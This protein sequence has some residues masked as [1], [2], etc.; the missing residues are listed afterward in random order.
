MSTN[1]Y[2]MNNIAEP[3]RDGKIMSHFGGIKNSPSSLYQ[4]ASS[5]IHQGVNIGAKEIETSHFSNRDMKNERIVILLSNAIKY[6]RERTPGGSQNKRYMDN[7]SMQDFKIKEAKPHML[8]SIYFNLKQ[9]YQRRVR[10]LGKSGVDFLSKSDSE[11]VSIIEE[12]YGNGIPY[13]GNCGIQATLAK[14]YLI[15][16]GKELF[17]AMGD[18]IGDTINIRVVNFGKNG[19]H[20]FVLVSSALE[21]HPKP[22]AECISTWVCDPWSK[23]ACPASEY[24]KEIKSKMEKWSA[25]TLSIGIEKKLYENGKE[26]I[27]NMEIDPITWANGIEHKNWHIVERIEI[28]KM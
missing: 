15:R 4:L 9:E 3:C 25:R 1:D 13:Y 17:D 10:V 21:P 16:H 28:T 23:I 11:K 14:N 5:K 7:K 26:K 19:D 18:S 2:E 24:S 6:A 22:A 27:I 12:Q 8:D 20:Q